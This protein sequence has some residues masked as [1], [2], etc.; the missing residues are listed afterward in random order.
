M[1]III[2]LI[3]DIEKNYDFYEKNNNFIL[4]NRGLI[5]LNNCK[6]IFLKIL[7]K[8]EKKFMKN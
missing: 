7:L 8:K 2:F 3:I 6:Q 1:N 5:N 4:L